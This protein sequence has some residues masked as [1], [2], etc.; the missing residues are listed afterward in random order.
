MNDPDG[1]KDIY[2]VIDRMVTSGINSYAIVYQSIEAAKNNGNLE[3]EN[4]KQLTSTE[5]FGNELKQEYY[6]AY[7][8]HLPKMQ[9]YLLALEKKLTEYLQVS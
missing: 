9:E 6:S 4:F 3:P 7:Q 2:A 8:E 5:F 1:L